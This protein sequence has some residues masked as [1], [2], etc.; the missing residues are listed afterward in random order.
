MAYKDLL[1]HLDTSKHT[2]HRLEIAV[3]LAGAFEA[4]LSAIYTAAEY[5]VPA[6]IATQIPVDLMSSQRDA[7]EQARAG[8]KAKFTEATRKAGL[9]AEWRAEEGFARDV[10]PIHA[11]YADFA[12]VGQNDPDEPVSD[13]D[14]ELPER[15]VLDS[16][17]PILAIPYAGRF[18]VI[19]KRVMVAWNSS[20]QAARAINEA[21][22]LLA[23]AD[24]VMVLAINPKGGP[25]GHGDIPGA[26]IA[27]HL[28]RHGIKAVASRTQAED[29]EVADVILSRAADDGTDLIVM[30]AYGHSR[31]RET[32]LGGATRGLL[33]HM[34]VPVFMSH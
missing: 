2:K 15:I 31:L 33:A 25:K 9:Q 5:F 30:G 17:R 4:H 34:T 14:R 23:R 6:Y 26:D 8:A 12:I 18:D 28:A 11:R 32:V 3:R 22:P 19:G 20:P 1:V 7:I 27:H 10:V 16:G 13:F 21:L 29:I 24:R